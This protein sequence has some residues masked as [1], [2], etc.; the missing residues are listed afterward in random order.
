MGLGDWLLYRLGDFLQK[1][2]TRNRLLKM[3]ASV[4]RMTTEKKGKEVRTQRIEIDVSKD[5]PT[6]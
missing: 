6:S 1:P 3:V 4:L 2:F 5:E